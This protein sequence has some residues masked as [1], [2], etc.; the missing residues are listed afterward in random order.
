MTGE[1]ARGRSGY[2]RALLATGAS[3]TL[4]V[5]PVF[6]LGSLAVFIRTDLGFSDRDLGLAVSIYYG[7]STL[8]SFTG[9][10]ISERL[11]PGRSMRIAAAGA[12]ATGLLMAGIVATWIQ[13][14][15]ALVIAGLANAVAQPAINLALAR[16][17]RSV[18]Q[19]LAF[20]LKQSAAPGGILVA[21]LAV[22]VIGLTVGWRWAFLLPVLFG[23]L[24]WWLAP[25]EVDRQGTRESRRETVPDLGSA[26]LALLAAGAVLAVSGASA[27]SAFF[28]ESAVA[29]N[30]P[31][32]EAGLWLT[33]G[34]IASI[35]VR[36]ALGRWADRRNRGFLMMVVVLLLV[37]ATG[38]GALGWAGDPIVLGVATV[39][40]FGAGWGWPGLYQFTVVRLNPSAPGAATGVLMIGMFAGGLVGPFG[41]G[42]LVEGSSYRAAWVVYA[43]ALIASALLVLY[44]RARVRQEVGGRASDA[45]G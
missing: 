25:V 3:A 7:A 12:V 28:V 17:V 44:A 29:Q 2:G 33:A 37:G 26:S 43:A 20:G 9:G 35:V 14:V 32:A 39:L 19:G 16:K 45:P 38:F 41:F 23:S 10:Q 31:P 30:H 5:L 4:A 36:V 11:G 13:L 21:G 24:V 27:L 18:D 1:A 34:S 6:L 22:P 40:A 15:G 8:F 42:S